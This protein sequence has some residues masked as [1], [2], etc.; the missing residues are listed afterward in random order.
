MSGGMSLSSGLQCLL[1]A[2]AAAFKG[3][4]NNPHL[5]D[6]QFQVDSGELFYAHMFVL[7]ARCP[8]LMEVVS[9][10]VGAVQACWGR[11]V[12]PPLQKMWG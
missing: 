12:L 4:V 9:Q 7:Y 2:L 3:M 6:V 10:G 5:S 1:G 8:Q 11:C